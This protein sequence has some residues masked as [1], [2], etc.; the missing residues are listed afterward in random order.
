MVPLVIFQQNL[1][2]VPDICAPAL[3]DIWNKEITT[4]KSFSNN[5]K[6][7]DVTPMFK[8][9]DASRLKNYRPVRPLLVEML[10]LIIF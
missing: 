4:Q 6:L 10:F 8:K 9:G 2:E 3:N 5:L 7:V 1:K